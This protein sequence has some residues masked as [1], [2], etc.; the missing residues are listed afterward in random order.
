[1]YDCFSYEIRNHEFAEFWLKRGALAKIPEFQRLYGGQLMSTNVD[2]GFRLLTEAAASG[3]YYA[4]GILADMYE[5]P[6]FKLNNPA[7]ALKY[8][9]MEGELRKH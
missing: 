3:D 2:E 1:M 9:E 8:R 4:A 6:K 7:L 5:D